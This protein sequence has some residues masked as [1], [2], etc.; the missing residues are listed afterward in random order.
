MSKSKKRKSPGKLPPHSNVKFELEENAEELFLE[1][2]DHIDPGQKREDR[3]KST[4]PRKGQ[5]RP[6]RT[7]IDLHGMTLDEAKKALDVF[8]GDLIALGVTSQITVI[9]GKGLH[10]ND[11]GGVLIKDIPRYVKE[12]YGNFISWMEE[13]PDDLRI[14]QVPIRGHFKFRLK[15]K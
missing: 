11:S 12:K 1:A 4:A 14:G 3:Q 7:K 10:S 13:S 5:R 15:A 8:V 2:L 6:T 9:T